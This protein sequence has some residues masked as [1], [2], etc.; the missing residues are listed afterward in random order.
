MVHHPQAAV[1]RARDMA[2]GYT[3][4]DDSGCGQASREEDE[5]LIPLFRKDA[6]DVCEVELERVWAKPTGPPLVTS[7]AVEITP[8]PHSAAATPDPAQPRTK[9]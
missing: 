2:R 9:P 1:L 7:D 3:E 8:S 4:G 5:R 6:A